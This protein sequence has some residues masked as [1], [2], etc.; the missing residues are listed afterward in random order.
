VRNEKELNDVANILAADGKMG[1]Y[2][3]AESLP[4]LTSKADIPR[5]QDYLATHY[6][7]IITQLTHE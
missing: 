2:I 6:P 5:V 4:D 3:I 7:H 1:A